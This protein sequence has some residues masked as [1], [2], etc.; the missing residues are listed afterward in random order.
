MG[1]GASLFDQRFGLPDEEAAQLI[2]MPQFSNDALSADLCHGDLMLQIC[3]N[4]ADS[5]SACRTRHR[6]E[7]AP[8]F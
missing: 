8:I 5:N 6:E 2:K 4:T 1:V 3:S 7:H